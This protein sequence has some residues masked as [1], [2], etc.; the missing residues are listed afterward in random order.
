MTICIRDKNELL[1][2]IVGSDAR[3]TPIPQLSE[4][5][6]FLQK[7]IE[8]VNMAYSDVSVEKHVIMPNHI[9]LI[10]FVQGMMWA[11]SPTSA[12]IPTIVRTL[13]TMVTKECA[14]SF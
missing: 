6:F 14:I 3:I 12:I 8:T 11:S 5:G 9:H 2:T 4:Y 10:L 1:G 7:H 13:K